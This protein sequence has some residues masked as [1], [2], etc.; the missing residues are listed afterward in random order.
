MTR[1]RETKAQELS[2]EQLDLV[3]AA[4]SVEADVRASL[5]RP[6]AAVGYEYEPHPQRASVRLRRLV[7][8]HPRVIVSARLWTTELEVVGLA[9]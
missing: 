4:G 7:H 8:L 2:V 3:A 5:E 1:N 9:R 6:Q